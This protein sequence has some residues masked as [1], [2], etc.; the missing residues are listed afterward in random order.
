MNKSVEEGRTRKRK[1]FKL[2]ILR[3][4]T[5]ALFND[6]VDQNVTCRNLFEQ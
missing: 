6:N 3:V 5:M 2:N 1:F 4:N